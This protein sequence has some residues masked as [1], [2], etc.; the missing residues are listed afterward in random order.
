M[1]VAKVIEISS[2]SAESFEDAIK[3]GI[4]R[5]SKTVSDIKGAWVKEQEVVVENNAITEYRVNMKV[6]FLLKE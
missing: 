1:A 2:A 6:T 3:Q 5:A 4:V